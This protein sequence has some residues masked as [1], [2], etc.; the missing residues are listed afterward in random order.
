VNENES[1]TGGWKIDRD[2]IANADEEKEVGRTSLSWKPEMATH[3][4]TVR[5][6][7]KDGDGEVYYGG[8]LL[9]AED[10][11]SAGYELLKWGEYFAGC[12]DLDTKDANG[13]WKGYM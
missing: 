1:G 8:F 12:S 13:E 10:G 9:E 3:P 2:H 4:E 6:R 5:F 11:E 7:L